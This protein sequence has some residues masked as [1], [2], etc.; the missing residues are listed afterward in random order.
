MLNKVFKAVSNGEVVKVIEFDDKSKQCIVEFEDGR[1][2]AYSSV[3]LKD[4]RRF[5]PVE[6]DDELIAEIDRQRKELGI[7]VPKITEAPELVPMPG[8]EKLGE[9]KK[10]TS[11]TKA[12][13]SITYR[14]ETKTPFEWGR[15]LGL[16]PK[17]IR[18]QLRK[19]KTPEEIFKEK[20]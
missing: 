18:A 20:K 6:S 4:K 14:G 19:G 5:I 17:Y 9:L 15:L 1:T 13:I 16:D 10:E 7:E 3:T 8:A 2:R 11:G 12:R